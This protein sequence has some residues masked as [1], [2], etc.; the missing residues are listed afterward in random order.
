[1][2]YTSSR[3]LSQIWTWKSKYYQDH[4]RSETFCYLQTN[5]VVCWHFMVAGSKHDIL[6]SETKDSSLHTAIVLFNIRSFLV[7][8]RQTSTSSGWCKK[9]KRC[10]IT[11]MK[12]KT[13][14]KTTTSSGNSNLLQWAPFALEGDILF[15][16]LGNKQ[17]RLCSRWRY[18]LYLCL[19]ALQTSLKR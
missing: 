2:F 15:I 14:T 9:A 3:Y 17:T 6:G 18:Y 13:K 8:V 1:M 4:C 12:T 16:I 5:K 10:C 7:V 11:W 19:F